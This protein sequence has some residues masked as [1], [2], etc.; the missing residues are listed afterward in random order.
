MRFIVGVDAEGLACVVGR[1]GKGLTASEDF[2]FAKAQGTREANAVARGLFDA[3]AEQVVIWDN[4]GGSLNLDYY[5]IDER[6][7]IL[8]GT[9]DRRRLSIVE[10]GF[11]GLVLLG[12][13]AMEGTV[14]G[15]L[16]HS[17]SSV[18]YQWMKVND[19]P[20]GEMAIDGAIAGRYGV[21][22][23]MVASDRAGC[24]EAEQFFP[25]AT[26]VE[27]KRGLSRNM[28]LSKSPKRVVR[29][30]EAAAS[31]AAT[32]VTDTKPFTFSSP[33]RFEKRYQRADAAE[34]LSRSDP[35]YQRV[36]AF[37]LVAEGESIDEFF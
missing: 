3:G 36:D 17:F 19:R 21:P 27:T 15:I 37:T 30:L 32:N 23:I 14:D 5:G 8:C 18:T 28:A 2:E 12:Y 26:T 31:E 10:E 13:H 25:W 11:D 22:V 29:E 7:E 35:R 16:A 9:G 6:C 1:R 24:S 20:V 33:L 34:A 4:H